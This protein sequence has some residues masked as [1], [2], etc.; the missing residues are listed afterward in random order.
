[1]SSITE[2]HYHFKVAIRLE[3]AARLRLN[4]GKQVAFG[5]GHGV[6]GC[7]LR[8]VNSNRKGDSTDDSTD[9]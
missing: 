7:S 5:L 6:K 1:M 2:P 4:Y 3:Y 9:D 8:T